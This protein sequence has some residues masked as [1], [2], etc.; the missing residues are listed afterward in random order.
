VDT[1]SRGKLQNV[2]ER[3]EDECD[4]W[5]KGVEG[6]DAERA[7]E[8]GSERKTGQRRKRCA[9]TKDQKWKREE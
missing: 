8:S 1:I 9:G 5:E 3:K 7:T 2:K 6:R 4:R